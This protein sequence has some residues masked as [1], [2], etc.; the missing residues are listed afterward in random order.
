MV[1]AALD[2][3][4][5]HVP[6][7]PHPLFQV[8]VPA[9]CPDVPPEILDARGQW[10]DG[11]AYD[12]AAESLDARFRKNSKIRRSGMGCGRGSTAGSVTEP[13]P[14]CSPARQQGDRRRRAGHVESIIW[15]ASSMERSSVAFSH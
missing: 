13:R 6:T 15:T 3:K 7:Q 2:G 1:S 8:E 11:A 14:N 9:A 12:L 5:D 10:N 4:L